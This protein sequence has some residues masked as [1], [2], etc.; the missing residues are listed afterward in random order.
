MSQDVDIVQ[1]KL[2]QIVL[3]QLELNIKQY[4]NW[5]FLL[6]LPKRFVTVVIA[7]AAD[8]DENSSDEENDSSG[9]S[10]SSSTESNESGEEQKNEDSDNES[11]EDDDSDNG[12]SSSDDEDFT[13][14]SGP[15]NLIMGGLPIRPQSR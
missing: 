12:E 4:C 15:I 7:D 8:E 11:S 5:C 13:L 10:F 14:P 9:S 3:G 2:V 6:H 1:V